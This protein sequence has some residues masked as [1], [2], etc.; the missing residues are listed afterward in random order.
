MYIVILFTKRSPKVFSFFSSVYFRLN[1]SLFLE[2]NEQYSN[3]D[4]WPPESERKYDI[5]LIFLFN[6]QY[7]RSTV[8]ISIMIIY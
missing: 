4:N 6:P 7:H 3:K 5:Q 8:V 1:R 2:S